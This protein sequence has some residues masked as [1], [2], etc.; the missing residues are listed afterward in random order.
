[1]DPAIIDRVL[2]KTASPDE[3]RAVA[4]W[5]ATDE[6]QQ[7]LSRRFDRESAAL[8]EPL[9]A[10][11]LDNEIPSERMKTGFLSRLK[12]QARTFRFKVVAAVLLPLALLAGAFSFVASRSGIF[13]SN[14]LAE[15]VVPYGE[16]M[17]IVL[18]DGTLVQLNSGSRLRY[19][20]SFGLFS[21]RVKL[22]GEAYFSVAKEHTRPFV[23]NLHDIEV[24]V[25]GTKFNAKAYRDD[26]RIVVSLD[27]GSVYITDKKKN[28][29]PLRVGEDAVYDKTSGACT[30]GKMDDMTEH[31]AW[32]TKSLNFYRTPLSVI[33]KTLERQYEVQ[34]TVR[35]SSLLQYRFSIS[36]SKVN[37]NDI[38]K[39]LEKVSKIRFNRTPDNNY[40]VS[41]MK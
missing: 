20:K 34:F 9:I 8:D 25:T 35:D 37:T 3:A 12:I 27:E 30:V 2:S 32:M 29:Y 19:P 22:S 10:E 33:L 36:T 11:W 17:R 7:Y 1:M 28:T 21:R 26:S 38:L 18:Q 24:K 23:V 14:D 39:D 41:L 15:I 6:G 4:E 31:G 40:E 5:F 13:E 16:Q